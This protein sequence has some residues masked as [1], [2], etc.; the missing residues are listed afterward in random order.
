[1]VQK[2]VSSVEMDPDPRW[3]FKANQFVDCNTIDHP[4][5]RWEFKANQFVDFKTHLLQHYW[6]RAG[7]QWGWVLIPIWNLETIVIYLVKSTR[8]LSR[9]LER[10]ECSQTGLSCQRV[11]PRVT[12]PLKRMMTTVKVKIMI[13]YQLG[14]NCTS[15]FKMTRKFQ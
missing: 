10:L 6:P 4:D 5:P 7:W 1:M 8:F 3:E 9:L 14:Y 11:L 13:Y 2:V 12:R 15:R